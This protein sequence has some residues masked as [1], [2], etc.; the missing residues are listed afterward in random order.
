MTTFRARKTIS[1]KSN[2]QKTSKHNYLHNAIYKAIVYSGIIRLV[3][4]F[5]TDDVEWR[6]SA[7]HEEASREGSAEVGR[8]ALGNQFWI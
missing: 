4:E 3:H 1:T 8:N 6:D 2:E 7:R 5:G